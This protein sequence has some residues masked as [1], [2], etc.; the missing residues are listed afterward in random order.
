[1]LTVFPL[2]AF[3]PLYFCFHPGPQDEI[4]ISEV[5]AHPIA[6]ATGTVIPYAVSQVIVFAVLLYLNRRKPVARRKGDVD[7]YELAGKEVISGSMQPAMWARA[8]AG[9][10]GDESLAKSEYIK[11]RVRQ[12]ADDIQQ[13]KET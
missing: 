3:I 4:A 2:V 8:L 13:S 5:K 12:V 6:A 1:L 7:P 10:N 9:S 11:M